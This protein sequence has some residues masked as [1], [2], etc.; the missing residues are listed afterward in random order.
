MVYSGSCHL[1][2]S[3]AIGWRKTN[4]FRRYTINQQNRERSHKYISGRKKQQKG[5]DHVS[6]MLSIICKIYISEL[7]IKFE[8]AAIWMT[9]QIACKAISHN[10]YITVATR[11]IKI[12]KSHRPPTPQAL[13]GRGVLQAECSVDKIKR[14]SIF[15]VHG[16]SLLSKYPKIFITDIQYRSMKCLSLPLSSPL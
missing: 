7:S 9:L 8:M 4:S 13:Y 14:W 16:I 10:K 12:F 3:F 2:H 6:K 5:W 15:R 1:A 11:L